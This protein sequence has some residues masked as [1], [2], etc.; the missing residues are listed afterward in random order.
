MLFNSFQFAVFFI[1]VFGLYVILSH[2][3][4]NRLLLVAS[5]VFYGA[6][7]WRF[8]SLIFISTVLDYFCGLRIHSETHS[9][10][11]RFFLSLSVAGNLTIL[12]FFKYFN[13]FA[14]NLTTL[15]Q[16][17]G[18]SIQPQFVNIILP[19]GISFYTFQTT[20]VR[21]KQG[22]VFENERI[23]T[24]LMRSWFSSI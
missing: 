23:S 17:F 1:I 18:F 14:E 21:L 15:V 2:R 7:D 5:Y 22:R 13:F 6:W 9:A 16:T 4:Q 3:W 8:L 20:T 24:Y 19:V 12:G 10:R 11:R